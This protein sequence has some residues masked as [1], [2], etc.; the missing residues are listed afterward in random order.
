MSLMSWCL[1]ATL[2]TD[3]IFNQFLGEFGEAKHFYHG[4]TYTGNPIACNVALANIDIFEEE[5]TLEKLQPKIK[6]LEKRLEEF[7]ELKQKVSG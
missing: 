6:L 3:E 4:H 5:K 1:A 2:V 7:W